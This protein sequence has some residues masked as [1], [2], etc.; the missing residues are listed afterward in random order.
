M[1][2]E[3][4]SFLEILWQRRNERMHPEQKTERDLLKKEVEE[5]QRLDM[6]VPKKLELLYYSDIDDITART[7]QLYFYIY[8]SLSQQLLY[9]YIY[10]LLSAISSWLKQ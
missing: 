1:V 6:Y 8:F 3:F 9:F 2:K 7:Q 10:F 5:S 4:L